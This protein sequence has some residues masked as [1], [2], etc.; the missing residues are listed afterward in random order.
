MLNTLY[1]LFIINDEVPTLFCFLDFEF[2]L[3]YIPKS[4]MIVI[5]LLQAIVMFW[6]RLP[7]IN[8]GLVRPHSR[9]WHKAM[10]KKQ[11][12]QFVTHVKL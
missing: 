1:T 10:H 4:A 11:P 3:F 12:Q 5:G 8:M 7:K 9:G 2:Y 6:D